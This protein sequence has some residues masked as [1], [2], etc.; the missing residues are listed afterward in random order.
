MLLPQARM[1]SPSIV[2]LTQNTMPMTSIAPRQGSGSRTR[3]SGS[4]EVPAADRPSAALVIR[5][6]QGHR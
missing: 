3:T 1:V 5:D 2:S 6:Q 4:S